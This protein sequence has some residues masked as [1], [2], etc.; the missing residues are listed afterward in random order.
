LGF[1]VIR[2]GHAGN[3]LTC[4]ELWADV[5][6]PFGVGKLNESGGVLLFLCFE[7]VVCDE[8]SVSEEEDTPIHLSALYRLCADVSHS[9]RYV[10]VFR[11]SSVLD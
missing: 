3:N 6:D 9:Y 5:K 10:T 2:V 11:F 4:E 8:Y 1:N 7:P